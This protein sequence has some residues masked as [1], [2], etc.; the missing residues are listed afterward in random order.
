MS[1]YRTEALASAMPEIINDQDRGCLEEKEQ[2]LNERREKMI[3]GYAT[4]ISYTDRHNHKMQQQITALE[5][6]NSERIIK[7]ITMISITLT[8]LSKRRLRIR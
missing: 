5:A 6:F 8:K 7:I 1:Q 3:D 4:M 2:S